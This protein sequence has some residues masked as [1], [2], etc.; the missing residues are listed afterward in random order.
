MGT[1]WWVSARPAGGSRLERMAA[2]TGKGRIARKPRRGTVLSALLALSAAAGLIATLEPAASASPQRPGSAPSAA[3]ARLIVDTDIFGDVD[4]TGA[5]AVANAS[6]DNGKADLI[7]V[8]VDTPSKWGAPAADAIN[9]YYGHGNVPIGTLKPNDDSV[10]AANYPQYLAQHFP[11]SLQDGNRAPDATNLYRKILA[12]QPD[13]SVTIAAVGF[14]TNLAKLLA[15][16]PDQYSPLT[17][18]ELVARK[19]KLLTVMGGQY[20]TASSCEYNFAGPAPGAGPGPTIQMVNDWPTRIVFDGFEVGASIM[21]G[22]ALFSQ[23]PATDPVRKAYEI[24]VGYGNDRS[25]WDPS[26]VFYG[27]Y[28]PEDL[29]N[30][31]ADAGSNHVNADGC[32]SWVSSPV[33]DQNYLIKVADDP[34]IA[35]AIS[36]LMV[37]PPRHH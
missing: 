16:D 17:G 2:A 26:N 15:S 25:S 9:T 29:F 19:V 18:R 28:G 6:I 22:S 20:P 8:M 32:N 10:P 21:T 5:L 37:Q 12:K 14:E 3:P 34:T 11:N 35:R 33:K 36:D 31:N 7:G 23:T 24:Y 1:R 30:Y 4:D 27:I 13:H